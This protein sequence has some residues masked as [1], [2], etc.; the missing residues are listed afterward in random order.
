MNHFR[1]WLPDLDHR[2]WILSAGRLLSQ[3]GN[4]FVLFYAPI[5]FVNQVGLS[6]TAVGLGI[7]SGSIAGIVGRILG[8]SLSDSPRWGQRFTLLLSAAISA[9]AD[10]ALAL[11][12][13]FP[14]FPIGNWLMGFGIGLYW[15]ATESVVADLSTPEQRNEA[16]ALVRYP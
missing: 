2:V 14:L 16:F 1:S 7:G 13:D 10:G 8:G 5:F 11:S 3:V 12:T 9:I 15:P 4:G 6:V